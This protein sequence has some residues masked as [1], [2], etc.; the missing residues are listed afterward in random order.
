MNIETNE[1]LIR[2]NARI[3]QVSMI[4]GLVVLVGGMILS[5]RNAEQFGLSLAA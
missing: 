2:R 4:S 1:K 3:A 5:F